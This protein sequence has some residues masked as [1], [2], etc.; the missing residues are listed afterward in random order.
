MEQ[1]KLF[2][3]LIKKDWY[4]YVVTAVFITFVMMFTLLIPICMKILL[5]YIIVNKIPDLVDIF[6]IIMITIII[7]KIIVTVLQDFL[8]LMFEQKIEKRLIRT[9]ISDIFKIQWSKFLGLNTGDLINRASSVLN[10]FQYSII[11]IVYYLSY[12]ILLSIIILVIMFMINKALFICTLIFLVLHVLNFLFF[13]KKLENISQGYFVEKSKISK[14]LLQFFDGYILIL[15]TWLQGRFFKAFQEKIRSLLLFNF[16]REVTVKTQFLFQQ[17]LIYFNLAI[18]IGIGSTMLIDK[19]ISVG[20]LIVF[21]F[22]TL[23]L[24]DPI[25]RLSEVNKR[26]RDATSQLK[27]IFEIEDIQQK[28]KSEDVD[29]PKSFKVD[30]IAIK[31]LTFKYNDEKVIFDNINYEFE[32][33][34]IYMISGPSGSGKTSLFN[35]ITRLYQYDNGEIYL[36]NSSYKDL[37]INDVRNKIS[38][39]LQ[40]PFMFSGTITDN[41]TCFEKITNTEP[42]QKACDLSG[43]SG[44]IKRLNHGLNY[45]VDESGTNFSGGEKQRLNI[46]RTLYDKNKEKDILLF[47]EPSASLDER[48][49]SLLF[50]SLNQIKKDKIILVISHREKIQ[51]YCDE[52]I[53]I[54]NGKISK[55]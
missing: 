34:K 37:S 39:G 55:K 44:F 40:D 53:W 16:K 51:S 49:E 6:F 45:T 27:L 10:T 17:L 46:A 9:Y 42:V 13:N 18:I 15:T 1:I 47:D 28:E 11:G 54:E 52:I 2:F 25:Y 20:T 7:S 4:L 41:I 35:L 8:Y 22:L 38:I 30:K 3:R 43:A 5:D 24:Y 48:N 36:N 23:Y 12:S 14:F 29:I 33:N 21:I 32:K 31:N 19:Q 26:F 50:N